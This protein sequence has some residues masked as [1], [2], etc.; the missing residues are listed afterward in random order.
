MLCGSILLQWQQRT[1]EP[2]MTTTT[3]TR[4]MTTLMMTTLPLH[5]R[6]NVTSQACPRNIANQHQC[7]HHRCQMRMIVPQNESDPYPLIQPIAIRLDIQCRSQCFRHASF[8][9]DAFYTTVLASGP[10]MWLTVRRRLGS[11]PQL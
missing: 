11:S 10:P 3:T 5:L 1:L 6:M 2:M 9:G 7:Q 8:R 4:L